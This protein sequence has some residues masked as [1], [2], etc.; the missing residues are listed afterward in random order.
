[1][2]QPKSLPYFY[3]AL[4][5]IIA[6][7]VV[8]DLIYFVSES[9]LTLPPNGD[10]SAIIFRIID[11]LGHAFFISLIFHFIRLKEPYIYT[12]L[13]LNYLANLVYLIYVYDY[14]EMPT[15]ELA[16]TLIFI[17]KILFWLL[18][19]SSLAFIYCDSAK[20]GLLTYYGLVIFVSKLI[21]WL[22]PRPASLSYEIA[23]F[24]LSTAELTIIGI[25]FWKYTRERNFFLFWTDER[26]GTK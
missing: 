6:M 17:E 8:F 2:T 15:R 24:V 19:V 25:Y 22:F 14:R 23:L 11:W 26:I 18:V 9:V 3:T 20:R 10:F 16:D 21:W 12:A 4:L 7:C 1:M 5:I 13:L